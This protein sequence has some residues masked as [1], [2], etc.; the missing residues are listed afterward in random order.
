MRFTADVDVP[1]EL[2]ASSLDGSLVLFV[3]AGVSRNAPSNLPLFNGLASQVAEL[4]GETFSEET[5]SADAYLGRLI[6]R[7]PIAREQA[8]GILGS[9][10]SLHNKTHTAIVRLVSNTASTR[11][12]TT[13]FDEHLT[14]AATAAGI[15][16][17]DRFNGPAVP[18][19]REFSG[20]VHLHGTVLRPANELV[21]TDGD[22][23]RAYLT[24]GWAR[25]FVQEL[26]LNRVVLFIGYSHDDT[27]MKYIARGLPPTTKRF[28]LT[29]IGEHHKWIDLHITPVQY[30]ADNDH[31]ALPQ[32]LDAWSDRLAM[33]HLDHRSRVKSIVGGGLPKT[34]VDEDYLRSAI[35]T[36]VGVRA[37]A[38]EAT[39]R[40]WLS[41]AEQQR[42]FSDLFAAGSLTSDSSRQLANWFAGNYLL[43]ESSVELALGTIARLGP[44]ANQVLMQA[45]SY[46]T[47][48]LRQS[49]PALSVRVA[50]I[51][52]A[53]LRT[54]AIEPE[55]SW[56]IAQAAPLGSASV[57]PF[58][59]R[60]VLPRLV[61]A[62]ARSWLASP[63]ADAP[64][65]IDAKIA[66]SGNESD[67]KVMLDAARTDFEAGAVNVLQ[68]LEQALRDGYD[69]LECFKPDSTWDSWSFRRSAIE[70]HTQDDG[71]DFES[72]LIDGLRDVSVLLGTSDTSIVNRWLRDPFPIFRRLAV[73]A[74]TEDAQTES[75][76]KADILLSA[77][78]LFDR[79]AKHEI[80]RFLAKASPGLDSKHREQILNRVLE[81]APPV[82]LPNAERF[83]RRGIFDILEWLTRSVTDWPELQVALEAILVEEPDMG[84]RPHPDL[85]RFM[86][87]G[88]WGG[89]LPFE[90]DDF[91]NLIR[92]SG[93]TAAMSALLD[94]D[95]SER[96]FGQPDW[97]DALSL[98][99]LVVEKHPDLGADLLGVPAG[100]RATDIASAVLRGWASGTLSD[101]QLATATGSVE[102]LSDNSD[103]ARAIAEFALG[104]VDQ[105]IDSRPP[106]ELDRLDR[107][108]R[109]VWD[110]NVDAFE[111]PDTDD[112][113]SIGLNT[114]PGL[115]A[116]YWVNRIRLR[117]R[118]S[119]DDWS[120]LSD[121]EREALSTMLGTTSAAG[122]G[123]LAMIAGEV[124]FLYAAD[125]EYTKQ[126]VF[127]GFDS[128]NAAHANQAWT[129][130]LY[131]PRLDDRMLDDGFWELLLNASTLAH[132]A[133]DSR[134]EEQYWQLLAAIATQS[135]A[136][137]VDKPALIDFLAAGEVAG[138]AS[139]FEALAY[140][141]SELDSAESMRV[142]NAWLREILRGRTQLVPGSLS[143][144]E[145]TAW[146][147]LALR[148]G[149]AAADALTLTDAIPG[150]LGSKTNFDDL[151]EEFIR[152]NA[153]L[154]AGVVQRRTIVTSDPG[155]HVVH[156]LGALVGR[157]KDA[158][159]DPV[160]LRELVEAA[161][162]IGIHHASQ[163]LGL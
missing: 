50:T 145:K 34:P 136:T 163:W 39:G 121:N 43:N 62:E 130:F 116:Q 144:S 28:V 36:P 25:R 74:L 22:F 63:D 159:A 53:A 26:F 72:A 11:L 14:Y 143:S 56:M 139:F 40:D 153:D 129:S 96:E 138:L 106:Y 146:G 78:S 18:L 86:T 32:V 112:W 87:S 85:D 6:D 84:I 114:W 124:Y 67:V 103:L 115:I 46:G 44:V 71:R 38:D 7:A 17:G 111:Q 160:V 3:G 127:P 60:A 31:E 147:D 13:N 102:R 99:R 151:P 122:E 105:K 133:I 49:N 98:V 123:P 45:L 1:E 93:A 51:F 2:V 95:Y 97:D 73:H 70:P 94:R 59:R 135:S 155:W 21:L 137:S 65:I 9:P 81:G 150:P 8:K 10:A 104:A 154:I 29:D 126:E 156:E 142:W 24:D 23:G 79:Q 113:T 55:Q 140:A 37:F 161:L 77:V 42:S 125:P 80:F 100:D 120:C 107:L 68:V 66:W 92:A 134:V 89:T 157:L 118:V 30:P 162:G 117:W 47:Y 91:V 148:C 75:N 82:D 108:C 69:L 90:V 4:H 119:R 52:S 131:H 5:M 158:G 48:D 15:D 41:W 64:P 76:D 110:Q 109:L 88:V 101:T 35:T 33:G 83:R 20:I 132:G 128:V 27:V 19:A 12:V 57:M 141:L 54:D 152:A 58:L 16:L 61:L 149:P